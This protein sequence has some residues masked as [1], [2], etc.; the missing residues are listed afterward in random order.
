L[1]NE[2]HE[3]S[4]HQKPNLKQIPM[5]N[6]PEADQTPDPPTFVA[7]GIITGGKRFPQRY[8]STAVNVLVIGY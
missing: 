6:P 3:N 7:N 5:T 8:G 1:L 4:K 2:N